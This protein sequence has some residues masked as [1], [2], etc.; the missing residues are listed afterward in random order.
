MIFSLPTSTRIIPFMYRRRAA[1]IGLYNEMIQIDR[2]RDLSATESEEMT[3]RIGC[4]REYYVYQWWQTFPKT[5]FLFEIGSSSL[6]IPFYGKWELVLLGAKIITFVGGAII[7]IRGDGK[8]CFPLLVPRTLVFNRDP[9]A[10]HSTSQRFQYFYECQLPLE[11][12]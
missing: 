8:S 11:P 12:L 2:L 7:P 5:A 1:R 3:D 10:T 4:S 6:Y 9:L